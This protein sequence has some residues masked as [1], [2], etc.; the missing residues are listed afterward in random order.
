MAFA[1]LQPREMKIEDHVYIYANPMPPDGR[2]RPMLV[3]CRLHAALALQ[4][5]A[6]ANLH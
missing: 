5:I 6:D 2:F 4:G 3:Q 1:L